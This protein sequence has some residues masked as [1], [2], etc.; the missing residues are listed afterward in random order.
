MSCGLQRGKLGLW[1]VCLG[2]IVP[3]KAT[4][5]VAATLL[6]EALF[7]PQLSLCSLARLLPTLRSLRQSNAAALS[8][9]R[10]VRKSR[11]GQAQLCVTPP[12]QL[13]GV[14]AQLENICENDLWGVRSRSV[15]PAGRDTT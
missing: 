8:S 4:T 14:A 3:D 7:F 11:G 15:L 10:A 9:S 12:S 13:L 5:A 1:G 2:R 6:I